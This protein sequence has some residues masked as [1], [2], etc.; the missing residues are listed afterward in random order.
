MHKKIAAGVKAGADAAAPSPGGISGLLFLGLHP[1]LFAAA[2]VFRLHASNLRE[3]YFADTATALVIG[4]A[5]A[6]LLIV[7]FG[8]VLRSFG[9]KAAVLASLAIVLGLYYVELVDAANRYLGLGLTRQSAL[10][11]VLLA[12]AAIAAMLAW[13]RADLK[14]ANAI[15]NCIALAILIAPA[16]KV[17]S[18]AWHAGDLSFSVEASVDH[19]QT[20]STGA[21]AT[22]PHEKPDIYYFIFDR[23]GSQSVLA[24][25]YDFDNS[26]IVDFLE[27][28]GFYV[29]G[30]SRAN[31]LKTAHSLASTF[32]MDYLD[33]L[34]QDPRSRAGSWHPIYDM[35]KDHRV[36]RFLKSR[37]YEFI[38]VGA[39]WAPTQDSP[40]ADENYNFGFTEFDNRY[41]EKTI[42]PAVLN[43]V[44]P[45]SIYARRLQ[46]DNGQCQRVPEQIARVKDVARR[47][48]PTFV[49]AHILVPHD[50]YVFTA[51]GRCLRP[52][53]MSK[54]TEPEAYIEQVRFANSLI[55]DFVPA[56]LAGDGPKPIIIIQA[57][58]GPFPKRYRS[59]N[60]SWHEATRDEL[61]IKTGILNAFY[62]PDGDYRDL[63]PQ[64]TSVNTFRIVFDKYF[65]T[66]MGRLPERIN[67]FPDIFNIYDFYDITDVVRSEQPAPE[68]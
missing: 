53:E 51:D 34:R 13:W 52:E 21:P 54:R 59:G 1:F 37:G 56:L 12:F 27:E 3:T 24:E 57:D 67:A 23:Y 18:Y 62:F 43:A 36:G 55:R 4:L 25:H 16:W 5:A 30:D 22:G 47:D 49:F 46:W 61:D 8:A 2:S 60:L 29:A 44:A 28:K 33:F 20:A 65:G 40:L 17:A 10:P 39:W 42:L 45:A 64:V 68:S 38:Q 63:D 41:L 14:P 31:Y 26:E 19:I 6:L 58:E 32:H 66:G 11:F 50:P 9:A 35:V 48:G 7:V 15:L